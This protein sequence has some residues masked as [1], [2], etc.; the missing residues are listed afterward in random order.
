M[1][2]TAVIYRGETMIYAVVSRADT[3][4][5]EKLKDEQK[6]STGNYFFYQKPNEGAL[7]QIQDII[8][9]FIPL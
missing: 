9:G 2:R 7:R 8:Y 3:I 6:H 1:Y 5:L 4:Q